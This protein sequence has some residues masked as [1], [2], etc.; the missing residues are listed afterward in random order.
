MDLGFDPTDTARKFMNDG[1][2]GWIDPDGV[3]H[4]VRMYEH[5]SFFRNHWN[6]IPE[7]YEFWGKLEEE[8]LERDSAR[9]R[10]RY[11]DRQW[12]EYVEP[13]YSPS[14]DDEKGDIM[15]IIL[16]AVYKR[17]WGRVGSH[18]GDKFELE[19]DTEHERS[20]TRKARDFAELLG[21]DV[22]V[23]INDVDWVD[24]EDYLPEIFSG[25]VSKTSP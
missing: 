19:C 20:L 13:E 23:R 2:T 1:Q 10:E 16:K 6:A 4:P 17:G 11:P 18:S 7:I 8:A 21:R 15:P 9:W 12:H 22:K 3:V 24:V 14:Y 25:S 5:V